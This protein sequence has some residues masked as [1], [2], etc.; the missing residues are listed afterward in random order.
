MKKYCFPILSVFMF[1]GCAQD[2][3]P[4]PTEPTIST[5]NLTVGVVQKEIKKG[6]SQSDVATVL[7]SP[8]IVS[9]EGTGEE[10]WIYD[11]INTT[12]TY[13]NDSTYGTILLIGGQNSKQT[14]S[15]SQ[16]TL[17]IIIKFKEG[18]VNEYKYHSSKF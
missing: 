14:A 7:G 18:K 6:M 16:Q 10:A 9:S 8:N 5:S 15:Y 4:K 11:K 2:Y 17:T 12:A 1:V 3:Q 13:S